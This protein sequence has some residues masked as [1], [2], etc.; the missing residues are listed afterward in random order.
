MKMAK[1]AHAKIVSAVKEITLAD[2]NTMNDEIIFKED[3]FFGQKIPSVMVSPNPLA[4][5]LQ[6]ATE[7]SSLPLPYVLHPARKSLLEKLFPLPDHK[8]PEK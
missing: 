7:S 3:H 4:E 2:I 1:D 5:K 8:K 6:D